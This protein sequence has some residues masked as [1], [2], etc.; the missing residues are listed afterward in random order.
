MTSSELHLHLSAEVSSHNADQLPITLP[1]VNIISQA[2]Y[3]LPVILLF[4]MLPVT[5]LQMM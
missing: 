1:D 4:D 3:T 5:E 2:V